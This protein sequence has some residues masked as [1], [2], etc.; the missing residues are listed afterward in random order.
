MRS[1]TLTCLLLLAATAAP[2]QT[3]AE[4]TQWLEKMAG[5]P[6]TGPYS[7]SMN[8]E[9]SGVPG[10]P[11]GSK[12]TLK[13][14]LT[15][16]GPRLSHLEMSI[17]LGTPQPEGAP[18]TP[19]I[20]LKTISDGTT[21]WTELFMMGGQQVMKMTLDQAE[22]MAQQGSPGPGARMDPMSQVEAL[23]KTM[24][25]E[26]AEN[27][28]QLVKLVGKIKPGVSQRMP[29]FDSM[30]MHIDPALGFFR[31]IVVG[32]NIIVINFENFRRL[33]Q[34][35]PALFRYEPPAGVKVLDLGPMLEAQVKALQNPTTGQG[36]N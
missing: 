29:G 35:D 6:Q 21:V 24:D 8:A 32:N 5:I 25:F 28:P 11:P 13:G 15:Q 36:N 33:K 26:V 10:A 1:F 23:S 17:S 12:G 19:P 20:T 34:V 3:S 14:E 22:K 31:Q 16:N 4:A 2:A 9:I 18:P 7:V 27:T 30:V